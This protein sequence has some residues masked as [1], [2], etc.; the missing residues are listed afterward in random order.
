MST[1]AQRTCSKKRGKGKRVERRRMLR[2]HYYLDIDE[3]KNVRCR[4]CGQ[5]ICVASENYKNHVPR[6]ETL[7]EEIPGQRPSKGETLTLYYEYYCPG[8][9]TLLDV[10]VAERGSP[11]LWDIQIDS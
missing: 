11:P 5:I 4:K 9:F 1:G 3:N 6:A 10:E 7:P 8:C 2:I